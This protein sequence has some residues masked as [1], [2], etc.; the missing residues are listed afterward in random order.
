[1]MLDALF[2]SKTRVRLLRLLLNHPERPFFVR[3]LSRRVGAQIN[4]VRHELEHLLALGLIVPTDD[5]PARVKE[6]TASDKRTAAQRKYFKVDSRCLIYPELLALFEKA[7]SLMCNDLTRK[8]MQ[9]GPL[10]YLSL[11]GFFVQDKT[12]TTDIFLVGKINREKL[13][14][15]IRAFEREVGRE[16]NYTVMTAEEFQYRRE[17]TDRFLY[18]LLDSRKIVVVD[19]VTMTPVRAAARTGV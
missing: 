19:T 8:L 15:V 4:A 3:E 13:A 2:G 1:M 18:T 12:A 6:D 14:A 9:V 5:R 10:S 11:G 7:Q 16:V 17:V